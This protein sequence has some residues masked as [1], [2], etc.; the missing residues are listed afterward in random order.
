MDTGPEAKAGYDLALTEVIEMYRHYFLMKIGSQKGALIA[1]SLPLKKATVQQSQKGHELIDH[2]AATMQKEIDKEAVRDMLKKSWEYKR[3]S[4]V[5]KRCVSCG[6]C[7]MACPTCFCTT[8]EETIDLSGESS[9]GLR[10]WESCFNLS[11]SY[12]H[13]GSVRPNTHSMYR[14]WLTHK[15]STWWDQFGLSGCVGCGRCIAWCPVGIDVR[16]ELVALQK[17][18]DENGE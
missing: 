11:H 7:T 10:R 8:H 13:G 14:Q 16:E 1:K 15:F 3:Y 5:A 12:I 4:E 18:H 2:N 9:K 6:N 17:E